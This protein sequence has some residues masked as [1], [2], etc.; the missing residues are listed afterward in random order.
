MRCAVSADL[1]KV[2]RNR[3]LIMNF[4]ERKPP[5]NIP[6]PLKGSNRSLKYLTVSK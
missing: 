4:K 5:Y 1:K 2:A 6:Y 3:P